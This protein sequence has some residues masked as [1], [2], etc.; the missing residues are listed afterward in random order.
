MRPYRSLRALL[1]DVPPAYGRILVR[2]LEEA[3]WRLRFEHADGTDELTAALQRR[4][5]G[6]VL[7][8]GDG[9][10]AVPARKAL[11]L[12]RLAD[13]HLPFLAVSP[14]VH[15]GDLAAVVRGLDGAAAVVPDPAELPRALRRA[16]ESTRLRR[17]V[18]G[19]HRFLLAQQAVTD[20]V[21]AGLEP[22]EL[23]ARVLATLGETLG[24]TCGAVWR[25]SEDGSELRCAATWHAASASPEAAALAESS[26]RTV[27]AAGQGLPGRV[28]AFRRP[29]WVAEIGATEP[30]SAMARRAG[31]MTATA[32]PIAIADHCAGVI[33]FFSHG[34]TEPNPEVSAMFA[35]VGGQLAQYLERRSG[36]AVDGARRWLDATEAPLLALDAEGRVLLANHNACA[37][38]GRSEEQLLGAV[39]VDPAVARAAADGRAGAEHALDGDRLVRWQLTPLSEGDRV[40]GTWAA[41]SV[42]EAPPADS[43]EA[44]LRRALRGDQLRLHYQPIFSLPA[45]ELVAVEALLRWEEPGRGM[46]SPAEFIPVAEESGLI[47]ELGDWVLEAVCAQQV[48]W[49]AA[50]LTP[51]ISFNV[52]PSQLRRGDF[53][54]RVHERIAAP[55]VDPS[56][57]TVELTE[58]STLEDPA[59]AEGLVRELDALGLRIALDDFGTG[60]SSLSRLAELPVSTLKID[61]AFLRGVPERPDAAAVV[62]AILQ[63]ARALGRTAVAE[64]VETEAQREFLTSEGC[65]LAQGFLLGAPA[66]AEDVGRALSLEHGADPRRAPRVLAPG[67]VRRG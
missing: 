43:L 12:A 21:A 24:W 17:R 56:R 7:Y 31:L 64:G 22:D 58:S 60:Y 33:E 41:G 11:A 57:L 3:G 25:P 40:V 14:Y 62:T 19:A 66:P 27:L 49:A 63:L 34:I 37:L 30:R 36:A 20:H 9:P 39:W 42:R 46:I 26:S 59:L 47:D 10:R 53:V 45:G 23:L 38:V 32:F 13:P 15:A 52:S 6:A 2:A 5:W 44:R 55:G 29:S 67:G 18:G 35:T 48:A 1:V 8:G 16:L 50:G 65:P 54:A 61:R 28:W 51:N 4:G